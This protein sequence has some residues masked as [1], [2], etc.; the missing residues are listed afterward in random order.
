MTQTFL[1]ATLFCRDLDAS[2]AFYGDLLALVPVEQKTIEGA[3]AGG[4]LQLPPCKMRIAMLA[5]APDAPVILALF[6]IGGV[7]L[8]TLRAPEGQ[9]MHGQTALV[10]AT[11][12]FDGV[13]A[14]LQGAGVRFLTPPVRYPKPTASERSSAGIYREMIFYDPDGMLVSVLQIDPLPPA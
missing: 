8:D 9:P 1:R 13:L 12:D 14:R 4:L 10:L 11:D 5:S 6:E 7:E 2:V 3:A